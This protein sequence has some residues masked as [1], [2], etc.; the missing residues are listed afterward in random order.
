[1]HHHAWLIFVFLVETRFHNVGQTSRKLL[2]SND[3]PLLAS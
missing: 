1:V 2:T 3:P